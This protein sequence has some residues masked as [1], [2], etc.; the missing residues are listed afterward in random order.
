[1]EQTALAYAC[2]RRKFWEVNNPVQQLDKVLTTFSAGIQS[3]F[4]AGGKNVSIA[5]LIVLGGNAADREGCE[6]RR[7]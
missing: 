6:G 1:V 4:N 2:R 7:K 3:E 5:D